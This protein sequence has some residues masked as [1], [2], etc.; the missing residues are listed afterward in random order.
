PETEAPIIALQ[1]GWAEQNP[2][3][4]WYY[5]R[6]AILKLGQQIPSELACISC[7]GIAYQMHGLVCIDKQGKLVRNSIIWCDSRAASIGDEALR[8]MGESYCYE[9][10]LNSPGN[11]TASKLAWV[12]TNEPQ[13]FEKIATVLLPG[14]YIA[15][16]LTGTTATTITGMSEGV[17]WDYQHNS[18]SS[19]LFEY[20]SFAERLIP[21]VLP[22]FSIHGFLLKSV[23]LELGLKSGIPVSYK[24]GDQPNNALSLGVLEAGEVAATAGTSGV[25]YAV[26][27]E[28]TYDA[29]G[30][31]NS[32]AHVNYTQAHPN[33][34]MLLCLNG[35]GIAN[36]WVKNLAKVSNYT[37]VN[38]LAATSNPGSNGVLFLPFG[39]GAERILHHRQ[40]NAV[41]EGLNFNQNTDADVCRAVQEG[42]VFAMQYGVKSMQ[43]MGVTFDIIKAGNANMF[44]SDV[45]V[46]TLVNTLNV[47]VAL[48]NTDGSVG[49]AVGAVVGIQQCD[50]TDYFSKQSVIKQFTPNE[51]EYYQ[52]LYSKWEQLLHKYI[53]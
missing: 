14:D 25:I 39:N 24:A 21:N 35:C 34:G 8:Q 43:Q 27:D 4:W 28:P 30:A 46:Q 16:R 52:E 38:A 3:D 1:D 7:I 23:A 50:A 48:Y 45:F 19:K 31:I 33:V 26:T 10:L 6:Q 37:T 49:A 9:H 5:V 2:N 11:F 20:F 53:Q 12:K 51:H 41:L 13:V 15:L 29:S 22:S 32:F 42:V 47:P 36:K 40:V 17:F 44:L 18:I